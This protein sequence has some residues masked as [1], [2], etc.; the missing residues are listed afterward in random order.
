[1]LK[2]RNQEEL[3]KS[4]GSEVIGVF[5]LDL[6]RNIK[7]ASIICSIMFLF[8]CGGVLQLGISSYSNHVKRENAFLKVEKDKMK[9][10]ISYYQYGI[11]GIQLWFEMSPL[12]SL[13]INSTAFSELEFFFD[14][15]VRTKISKPQNDAN[16]F[17]KPTGGSLDLSWFKLMLMSIFVMAWGFFSIRDSEKYYKFLLN[18]ARRGSVFWGVFLSRA[19]LILFFLFME[20][21]LTI[22]LF[23]ANG[24]G[25]LPVL[26]GLLIFLLVSCLVLL[27]FFFLGY[28][29]GTTENKTKAAVTAVSALLIFVF[30]WPVGLNT[31]FSKK[32]D[33]NMM[34]IYELEIR[35]MKI[36]TGFEKLI[37]QKSKKAKTREEMIEL[38][39]TLAKQ[40]LDNEF[41]KIENLEMKMIEAI[42]EKAEEFQLWSIFNP[43][44]FYKSVNNE[45]SSMGYNEYLRFYRYSLEKFKGFVRFYFDNR[46]YKKNPKVISYLKDD[47]YIFKAKPSLPKYFGVGV[48]FTLFWVILLGWISY[49]RFVGSIY[50]VP[51]N[52]NAFSDLSLKFKK[53]EHLVYYCEGKD[54]SNQVYNIFSGQDKGIP[55]TMTVEDKNIFAGKKQDFVYLPSPGRIPGN[56]KLKSLLSLVQAPLDEKQ[57][58][59]EK[60]GKKIKKR[61][62]ELTR[63]EQVKF[64]L[65]LGKLRNADLYLLDDIFSTLPNHMTEGIFEEIKEKDTL[66]LEFVTLPPV[67]HDEFDSY[68]SIVIEGSKYQ[69]DIITKKQGRGKNR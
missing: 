46:L 2:A 1:M 40:Y 52:K 41:S 45:L 11:Y 55:G 33:N 68:F 4:I 10:Y 43:V 42:R 48:L 20:F 29:S 69:T 31:I 54:F 44:T 22:I 67:R 34:S 38:N 65:S 36:L 18:F 7:K 60:L 49:L 19:L 13:Y 12:H 35:K 56:L 63:P 17:E 66:I 16:I 15:G 61:L 6:T 9:R 27:F 23:F 47:E 32:A 57:K 14:S 62:A 37:N 28:L 8:V 21:S 50:P 51:E 3:M 25:I 5:K 59:K 30:L 58:L 64:L 24:I 39:K 26:W 53:G